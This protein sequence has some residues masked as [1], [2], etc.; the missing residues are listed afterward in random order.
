MRFSL[1][2]IK[3]V[4]ALYNNHVLLLL[5]ML[6]RVTGVAKGVTVFCFQHT[7]FERL[8]KCTFGNDT[9]SVT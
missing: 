9:G 7:Y 6:G 1:V 5:F 2:Y 3:R 8:P 4:C